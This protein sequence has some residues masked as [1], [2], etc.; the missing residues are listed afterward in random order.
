MKLQQLRYLAAIV[1]NDLNITAAAERLHTSQPGVSKQ[2]KQLEDELGFPIFLRQGRTLTK[3]TPAGK[4]VIER[5]MKILKEVQSIK[6]LADE[7]KGQGRGSLSIGTTHTQARYV[8]PQVIR[9]FREKYPEV[10]LHLHQGTSEQIADMASR[11]RIDFAINTGS[12]EMFTNMVLLP[13][14]RWHRRVVVPHNHPLAK[15]SKLTIE[16]L[17]RYPIV[18]YVFGFTGPS[19]LQQIFARAGLTPHVAL[20]ARDADVIKTYVRLGLGVGIVASMAID[21]REDS[22]LVSI[23]ASHLFP[24]HLTWVG[25]HQGALLRGYMYEFLQIL[26]PHLTKR[27]VDRAGNASSQADVEA[28][29]ADV[30]LPVYR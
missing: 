25:F 12:Q 9:K 29:F 21:P 11:D 4:R 24:A 15:E 2:L 27:L 3:V 17:G 26:A 13:C 10:E 8:L 14:Y 30:T 20:T 18:T 16:M 7:Q 6:R 19:S 28:L 23:D 22:D 1:E 5:A